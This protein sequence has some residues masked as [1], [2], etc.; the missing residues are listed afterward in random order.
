MKKL[1]FTALFLLPRLL[2]A[3]SAKIKIDVSRSVGE[4]KPNFTF[5]SLRTF[6]CK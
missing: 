3:Q 4:I 6:L 1:I 5:H 2:W